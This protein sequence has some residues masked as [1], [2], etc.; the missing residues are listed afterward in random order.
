MLATQERISRGVYCISNREYHSS[1]GISKSGLDKIARSPA[2]YYQTYIAGDHDED[3]PALRFGALFHTLT[4][5]PEQYNNLYV[6]EPEINKRTNAGKEEY[7]A[8]LA[9]NAG[10]TII[11]RDENSKAQAMA[12]AVHSHPVARAMLQDGVAEYSYY[13]TDPLTGEL[14]KCRPDFFRAD[15]I[16]TDLKSCCD[17]SPEAFSKSI[18]NYRYYVQ[19]PWYMDGITQA[20]GDAAKAFCF[21]CVEKD[22]PY[23]IAIYHASYN[24]LDLG[25]TTYRQELDI[26]ARC[27]RTNEWPAYPTEIQTIDLP[28]WAY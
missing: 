22:P 24:M 1:E 6:I 5:E 18:Y 13:W 20:T 15:G 2:H 7:A 23:A 10:K 25:R 8:F 3:T 26:Y 11:T 9:E 28:A 17:A 12:D 27:R 14:C 21:V 16:V 4:L 19:A